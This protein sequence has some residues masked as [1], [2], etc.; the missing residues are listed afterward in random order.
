MTSNDPPTRAGPTNADPT[1]D[2]RAG[3]Q[4]SP[5]L[6]LDDFTSRANRAPAPKY[7]GEALIELATERD[8]IVCLCADLTKPTETDLFRDRFPDRFVMAG[9]AEANMIGVA[10]GMA[11][12]G[13][14][15][16]AHSFCVFLTRRVYDQIAMQVAYPRTNVKLVGFLPGLTT[17]LGVSHQAIDDVALMRALP[18]MTVIEPCGP[19]QMAAAAR[20][21]ADVDGPVY[22][23]MMRAEAALADGVEP[24]ELDPTTAQ[25]FRTGS[26]VAILA[27][28]LL[29][30]RAM[31]AADELAGRGI[32]A[33]VVNVH[34]IKPIDRD[35]V[36]RVAADCGAVVTAEN[37]SVIGGLGDAVA[38]ALEAGDVRVPMVR[39]GVDDT[40]AEGGST[41]YLFEK[42][43]LETADVVAAVERVLAR[44][45]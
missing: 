17:E 44:K 33:T 1:T 27:S 25:V 29:V 26:E 24:I 15:P 14:V 2:D 8:E 13:D 4:P 18:N 43:G 10:S 42:Y 5:D 3:E 37:H 23:R 28:G 21:A 7:Y 41:P 22:L 34:T 12:L 39:V 9:I 36:C 38:H 31:A 19:A 11:R 30:P 35:T 32:E 6:H 16:F 20:A 40:F 45:R